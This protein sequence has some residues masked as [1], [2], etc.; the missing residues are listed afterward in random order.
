MPF[1]LK[2]QKDMILHFGMAK[3]RL[4]EHKTKKALNFFSAFAPLLGLEPRTP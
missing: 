4:K 2:E 3:V 1:E